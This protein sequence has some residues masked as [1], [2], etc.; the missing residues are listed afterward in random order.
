MTTCTRCNRPLKDPASVQRGYGPIC[1]A[2]VQAD[3]ERE[4]YEDN[5]EQHID[6]PLDEFVICVRNENGVATNVPHLIVE[7]SPTGFE[8]G[9]GGSGPAD[10]ALNILEA[11]LRNIGYKGERTKDTWRGDVCFRL[12][13]ALHQ[14]FK[15]DFISTMDRAGGRVYTNDIIAWIKVHE[16]MVGEQ[17]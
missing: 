10:L 11:V 4:K 3:R 7:H 9:Y 17:L 2:A 12:A 15:W 14:P 5:G 6:E 1:W 13:Y 16:P 8:F